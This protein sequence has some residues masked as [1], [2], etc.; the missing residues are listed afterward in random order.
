MPI[1][2]AG[3]GG[4]F[5]SMPGRRVLGRGVSMGE[6]WGTGF[7]FLSPQDSASGC[8][9]THFCVCGFRFVPYNVLFHDLSTL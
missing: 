8:H 5:I 3:S 4:A 6:R 7:G 9:I 1:W 2:A